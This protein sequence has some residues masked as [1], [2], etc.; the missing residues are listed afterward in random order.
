MTGRDGQGAVRQRPQAPVL[1]AKPAGFQNGGHAMSSSAADRNVLRERASMLSS[2]SPARRALAN[3]RCRSW[4]SGPCAA[5]EAPLSVAVTNV[6][7]PGRAAA[8][9]RYAR[10]RAQ[11][12]K[13]SLPAAFHDHG[14][15]VGSAHHPGTVIMN[16][17]HGTAPYGAGRGLVACAGVAVEVLRRG[18]GAAALVWQLRCCGSRLGRRRWRPMLTCGR[19]TALSAY[20][21]TAESR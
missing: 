16:R 17:G 1:L 12:I 10:R 5:S 7:T 11:K 13:D 6:P 8:R 9:P 4:R 14:G 21:P 18:V 2:S 3:Q 20:S 15:L 19:M